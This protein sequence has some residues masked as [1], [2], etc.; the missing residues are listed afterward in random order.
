MSR[1]TRLARAAALTAATA[2][3]IGTIA[4]LVQRSVAARLRRRPDPDAADEF[5][6]P[7][8]QD[9]LLPSHDGGS[10]H[11]IARGD[12]PPI[13][14]SH[15][16]NL[17]VRTWTY[18]MRHLP[19]SGLR[20]I[21]FDHRGHGDSEVGEG[22]HSIGNLAED[23]RDVLEHFDVRDGIL[24]GHSM[25][26]V[27]VQAFALRHPEV[28]R[29]R[30]RGLVLLS[31]ICRTPVASGSKAVQRAVQFLTGI[32]P[33]LSPLVAT[34]NLGFLAARVGFGRD[35][36]PSHVELARQMILDCSHETRRNATL[37]LLGF[38]LTD[39][40]AK[41]E[42]PVLVIGG[43]A[44]VLAPTWEARRIADALP[45]ARIAWVEGAGHMV[46]LEHPDELERLLI[47]FA[48]ELGVARR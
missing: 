3:G 29:E 14:L 36:H 32:T 41:V 17:S 16:L 34:P 46:M 27:A 2:A 19:D 39:E 33:D 21:A 18:Q 20:A 9:V 35:P 4:Y 40:L 25:G 31:T 48:D 24:L 30:L 12:G 37:A 5:V 47:D 38:D 45:D 43:T 8:D 22:G 11:V 7:A 42:L 13:V 15:G 26:G 44:D 23:V 28:A 6:P 10:I 1:S